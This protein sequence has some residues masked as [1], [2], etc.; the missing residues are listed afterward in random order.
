MTDVDS[1]AQTLQTAVQERVFPGAVLVVRR[2]G[3]L[4][5]SYAVGATTYGDDQQPVT[6]QTVYDLASL[7]K[8]LATVTALALLIQEGRLALDIPVSAVLD[9]FHNAS[10]GPATLRQVLNHCAGLPAWRPYYE[11]VAQQDRTI[12]GFLGTEAA[13]AFVRDCIRREA[14][15]YPIGARSLYSDL[16][17]MILGW[18]VERVAGESLASFTTRRIFSPNQAE[19]M[20]YVGMDGCWAHRPHESAVKSY[21]VAPTECDEAWRGHLLCGEVHDENAF[22]L[23]RIAGHAGLFGTAGAV[24]AV[25]GLWVKAC[26]GD[27][28]LLEMRWA[29]EFVRRADL[30]PGSS[31]AL[32]W[33]TPSVPSS[34]GR[35]FSSSS[36]GHLGFTG[37]SLWVDLDRGLEVVLLSNRVYPTRRNHK[38]QAFRPLIHD[39]VMERWGLH[40]TTRV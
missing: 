27:E 26:R 18:V 37:T 2:G 20:G 34:S 23:G 6:L 38:I 40:K 19:P 21:T 39:L 17:F 14:L 25:S 4:V 28:S 10:V 9:E 32:G 1:V 30:A 22:A 12:P 31:W 29:Q 33:D 11:Q 16:G 15:V 5:A 3:E 8:P 13:C 36:F 35:H 7:T 24:L